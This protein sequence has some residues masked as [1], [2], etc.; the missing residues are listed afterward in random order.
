MKSRNYIYSAGM[1]GGALRPS[2]RGQREPDNGVLLRYRTQSWAPRD[3]TPNS[4]RG[5]LRTYLLNQRPGLRDRV[6]V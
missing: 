5:E 4:P 2:S 1:M 3:A 6:L